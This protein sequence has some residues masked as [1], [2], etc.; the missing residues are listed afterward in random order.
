[1]IHAQVTTSLRTDLAL[2]RFNVNNESLDCIMDFTLV[3]CDGKCKI[4]TSLRKEWK[5]IEENRMEWDIKLH[6]P[7]ILDLVEI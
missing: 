1:M 5:E 7:R 6:S 3:F 4:L 2:I